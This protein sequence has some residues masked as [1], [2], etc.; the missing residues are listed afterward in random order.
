[1]AILSE[2]GTNFDSERASE[3]TVFLKIGLEDH[4]G[5]YMELAY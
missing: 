4:D 5:S 3:L 2:N 1:M